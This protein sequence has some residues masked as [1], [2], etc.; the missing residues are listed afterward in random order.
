MVEG[1]YEE[2]R[3]AKIR[4]YCE[5]DVLNTYL[6]YLR[7]LLY[8]RTMDRNGYA[9]SL[10]DAKNYCL[11]ESESRSNINFF[12]DLLCGYENFQYLHCL[13]L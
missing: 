7:Y 4:D 2:G 1:M 11:S 3:I 6:V 10:S 9:E 13:N 5:L 12:P 8:S